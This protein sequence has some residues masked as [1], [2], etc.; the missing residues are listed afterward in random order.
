MSISATNSK[1]I[2]KI[3]NDLEILMK[4][5]DGVVNKV[6]D[7]QEFVEKVPEI[8]ANIFGLSQVVPSGFATEYDFPPGIILSCPI[9][10][11]AIDNNKSHF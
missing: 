6:E 3:V 9:I 11:V 7:E 5:V 8:L 4:F 1:K 2:K 10:I